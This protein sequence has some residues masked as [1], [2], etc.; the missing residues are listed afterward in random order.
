MKPSRNFENDFQFMSLTHASERQEPL[1]IIKD[2][3]LTKH[4]EF[5]S[6]F[7]MKMRF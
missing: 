7:E 1:E 4:F 2:V 6:L 5:V 3:K